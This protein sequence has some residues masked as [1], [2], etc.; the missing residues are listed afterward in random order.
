MMI[1]N[2][3]ELPDKLK[4]PHTEIDENGNAHPHPGYMM[5]KCLKCRCMF[6]S[7]VT[8]PFNTCGR[9]ICEIAKT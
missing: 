4:L 9:K 1:N 6:I 2:N 8:S 3:Y 7:A 5:K